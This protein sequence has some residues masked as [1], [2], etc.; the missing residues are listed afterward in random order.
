VTQARYYT[1]ELGGLGLPESLQARAGIGIRLEAPPGTKF[2]EIK[3]DALTF[4][5]RGGNELPMRIYEQIFGHA[6]KVVLQPPANP[7]PW[8][9]VAEK[10]AIR[11][12]GFEAGEGLLPPCSRSFHGYQLLHEYFAFPTRYMFFEVRGLR[13][14]ARQCAGNQMDLVILT[15]QVDLELE[16]R[17]D[18]TNFALFCSPVI[19]LFPKRT[20]R[21]QL[22]DKTE[23]YHVMPDRTRPLDFEV[24]RVMQATG[25]GMKAG[26]EQEFLPFYLST[27]FDVESAGGLA[28]YAVNRQPRLLSQHELDRGRRSSYGGSEVFLSLVD[29]HNAPYR[30]DLREM[31]IQALCTNRDL[32]LQI[33]IGRGQTDFTLDTSAPV[34]AVRCLAGPTPPRPSFAE[35]ETAWRAVSHLSLNY[36]SLVD[37]PGTQGAS[38]LREL[39]KLYG[40]A[41]D[42]QIRKQIEG[43]TSVGS[44]PVTRRVRQGGPIAFARGVEVTLTFD[45]EAF[46]GTGVF[47]LG[48]V[49]ERFFAKYVS[50]NSFVET[51]IKTKQRG[52]IMRWLPREGI[53]HTL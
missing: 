50:I 33:P 34:L 1:R 29:A 46:E 36:L 16:D 47:L 26:E 35:G 48:A 44:R 24:Y 8:R 52:E 28:Y 19:N 10:A 42:S 31:A 7:A 40:D 43:L 13:E 49:L 32:P 5:I 38:A 15:D 39:L 21:M 20:D 37:A 53:R 17:V 27:D 18:A 4:F 25:H 30:S 2:S 11:P 23:E 9:H 22:T 12:V 6:T 3:L 14:A 41:S 45:E 51:V